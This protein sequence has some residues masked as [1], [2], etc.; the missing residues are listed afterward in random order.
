MCWAVSQSVRKHSYK[1]G[2]Y[3]KCS[4][5]E[6]AAL[7]QSPL[8]T[9]TGLSM[10]FCNS[11]PHLVQGCDS[12]IFGSLQVVCSPFNDFI[13]NLNFSECSSISSGIFASS[14]PIPALPH[15]VLYYFIIAIQFS[16][17]S[18]KSIISLLKLFLSEGI[19]KSRR[20]SIL[21]ARIYLIVSG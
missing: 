5:R 3:S 17:H 14:L 18:H 19:D 16:N 9:L 6:S 1:L 11:Q 13:F 8:R 7:K 2:V 15:T 10:Y 21:L 4:Y 20:S 12:A